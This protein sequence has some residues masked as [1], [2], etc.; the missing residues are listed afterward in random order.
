MASSSVTSNCLNHLLE[1]C[2]P[3]FLAMSATLVHTVLH[4]LLHIPLYLHLL[5]L[6]LPQHESW[7]E[8]RLP[9]HPLLDPPLEMPWLLADEGAKAV[10]ST[11]KIASLPVQLWQ[12]VCFL[13]DANICR[14]SV[15]IQSDFQIPVFL[16][17]RCYAALLS[18]EATAPY[19]IVLAALDSITVSVFEVILVEFYKYWIWDEQACLS[20]TRSNQGVFTNDKERTWWGKEGR[21]PRRFSTLFVLWPFGGWGLMILLTSTRRG[22]I[23][24]IV[25]DV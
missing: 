7:S 6:C 2:K 12:A 19:I 23:F 18:Y 21:T 17:R 16:G 15:K 22:R 20:H 9:S 14:V 10:E 4:I 8:N 5:H 11:M 24:G 13:K 3:T 25:I 1:L